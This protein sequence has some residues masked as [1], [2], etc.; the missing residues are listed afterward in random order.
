[1]DGCIFCRIIVGEEPGS[2]VLDEPAVVAFLDINQ[3]APG[4]V[5]I[6]PRT[7]R[8]DVREFEP[9]LS[10]AVLDAVARVARAVTAVFRPDGLSV[11][12]NIG[13][14]GGQDVFH[15]HFHVYPRY[16]GDGMLRLYPTAPGRPSRAA[17]DEVA[18]RLRGAVEG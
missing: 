13:E 11:M 9:E 15:A 5:L 17:L 12:H 8:A 14:A 4:H 6:V 7:H 18:A 10:A 16:H 1:M 2:F 3:F